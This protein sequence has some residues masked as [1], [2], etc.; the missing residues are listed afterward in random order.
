VFVPY[1]AKDVLYG[2][3]LRANARHVQRLLGAS[4]MPSLAAVSTQV[5]DLEAWFATLSYPHQRHLVQ[6]LLPLS[7]QSTLIYASEC[8]G[9]SA[10]ADGSDIVS[11]L[12]AP[13]AQQVLQFLSFED[14]DCTLRVCRAWRQC[15]S[16][17]PFSGPPLSCSATPRARLSRRLAQCVLRDRRS[18]Q[19]ANDVILSIK[20]GSAPPLHRAAPLP[21]PRQ[22]LP[23]REAEERNIFCGPFSVLTL[24]VRTDCCC[25]ARL[26]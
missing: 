20:T 13:L 12:P 8:L 14:L 21:F 26:F 6:L 1:V 2:R 17:S 25:R 10:L 5:A 23:P 24:D 4:I 18:R 11:A 9:R 3:A 7:E 16:C 15:V 19:Q 22:G